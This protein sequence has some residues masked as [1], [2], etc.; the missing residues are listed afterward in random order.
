MEKGPPAYAGV[1]TQSDGEETDGQELLT[2]EVE[3]K[4]LS[5]P[6]HDNEVLATMTVCGCCSVPRRILG[7]LSMAGSA[8]VFSCMTLVVHLLKDS[9]SSWMIS[10]GRFLVNMLVGAALVMYQRPLYGLWGPKA[11]RPLLFARGLFGS[12]AM[13]LVFLTVTHLPVGDANAIIFINPILTALLAAII[14]KEPFGWIEGAALCLGF[15][16]VLLMV[17]PSFLF[18][19]AEASAAASA[20]STT[21][22]SSLGYGGAVATGLASALIAAFAYLCVRALASP[23]REPVNSTVIVMWFG[24]IGLVVAGAGAWW[25]GEGFQPIQSVGQASLL[26]S[27]GLLGFLGQWLLNHGLMLEKA[28]PASALRMLDVLF[29][30]IFQA[31]L[32]EAVS[33]WNVGG[34]I[35]IVSGT[36][37]VALHKAFAKAPPP[38]QEVE[39]TETASAAQPARD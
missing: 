24:A 2:V 33:W 26:L 11:Q 36:V 19:A 4:E 1:A 31:L 30:F 37:L 32:G 28:A 15:T 5:P 7:L 21:A 12:I 9:F 29:A 18:G 14:L 39:M 22:V 20:A 34:G 13:S 38:T 6:D 16:G 3:E 35:L 8:V 10:F 27:V 23:K 25:S 17:R